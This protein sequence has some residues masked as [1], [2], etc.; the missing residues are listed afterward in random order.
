MT[1]AGFKVQSRSCTTCIYRKDSPLDIKKLEADIADPYGGFKGYRIC[2]HSKD[3]C[4]RG[5]WNRWKNHFA[6]GQIAQRLNM[7]IFVTIDTL[8]SK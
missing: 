2:H 4:C 5:F 1:V 8:K 7:V 6:I 3:V